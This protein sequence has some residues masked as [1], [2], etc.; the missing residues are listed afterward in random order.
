MVTI[1]D[2]FY[3]WTLSD[4]THGLSELFLSLHAPVSPVE[5]ANRVLD[6]LVKVVGKVAL[7]IL[8]GIGHFSP[9]LMGHILL[10]LVC[11]IP[12][13]VHQILQR[14]SDGR[15]LLGIEVTDSIVSLECG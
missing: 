1:Q 11:A 9:I 15:R 13:I 5:V 8:I 7:Q 2:A 4:A 12:N 6:V 10:V 3:L 14:L